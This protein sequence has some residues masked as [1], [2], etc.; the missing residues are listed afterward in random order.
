MCLK[1]F[2]YVFALT[3]Q[4]IRSLERK[5]VARQFQDFSFKLWWFPFHIAIIEDFI[6]FFFFYGMRN[7]FIT[8]I[9]IIIDE[10][11]TS[12]LYFPRAGHDV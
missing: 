6:F 7:S 12:M 9:S 5:T 11:K 1:P 4:S 2:V 10:A 3:I 8:A